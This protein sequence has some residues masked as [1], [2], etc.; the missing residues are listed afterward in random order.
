MEK[1][2]K[3]IRA[4]GFETAGSGPAATKL[5]AEYG[6]DVITVEPVDG[7]N[8]RSEVVFDFYFLRKRSLAVNVK[9]REGMEIL[10]R[11]L[12]KADVFVS[13]Y[14]KR[15]LDRLGLDYKSLSK[16]YPRLVH[17]TITGYGEQGPMKDAPGFDTT[18]YWGRAGLAMTVRDQAGAPIVT[19][20][21]IGD[22]ASGTILAG[23]IMGALYNREKTGKGMKVA[24]SLMGL[25]VWQN[26]DQLLQAQMGVSYPLSR[27]TP[28]RAY[29]NTYPLKD[30]YFHLHTL[31]PERDMPK[32]LKI[33]GRAELAHDP[34]VAGHWHD[35]GEWAEHMRK[36]LDEG[37][38]KLTVAQAKEKFREY[39][40]A[41][42][43]ICSPNDIFRDPQAA[44]NHMLYTHRRKDGSE[45]ILPS[46]PL[47]FGEKN[48]PREDGEA[49]ELGEHTAQILEEYGYVPEEIEKWEERGIIRCNDKRQQKEC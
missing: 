1:I 46:S 49:P 20:S 34:A 29:A 25:G 41:F 42:G 10:H 37:F 6:A 33:I 7:V 22:I 12:S 40:L 26:H 30:G 17:A 2:L 14:R 35:S 9:T 39:D 8:T 36:I 13:N 32:V 48:E 19:P 45:C 38:Q 21:A 23:G 47:Q 44:E 31:D 4:V 27:L 5:L 11:L 15:A 3:G 24:I 28:R 43:E 18:A 16:Q